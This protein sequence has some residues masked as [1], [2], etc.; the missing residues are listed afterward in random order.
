MPRQSG[1]R[2]PEELE[3]LLED[4][5]LLRDRVAVAA[6]FE[7]GS[8]LA[9][10]NSRLARSGEES[11]M[12]ALALWDVERPYLAD[13]RQVVLTRDLALIVGER[14]ANVVRRDREGLWH[15]AI[16]WQ[17]ASDETEWGKEPQ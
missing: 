14:G 11:A 13:P 3:T 9:A 5:L 4:A 17:P 8:T 15:F 1:A 2:T 10:G 6:L 16:V 12:R 7:A